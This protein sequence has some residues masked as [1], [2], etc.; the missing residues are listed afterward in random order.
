MD[1]HA[2][3]RR[4]LF[5]DAC[6][7][8]FVCLTE[9]PTARVGQ[10][11]TLLYF[12][13]LMACC[14]PRAQSK[15]LP[16]F[17]PKLFD[18]IST[19]THLCQAKQF[20]SESSWRWEGHQSGK[21]WG[22]FI[23]A[24]ETLTNIGRTRLVVSAVFT[25]FCDSSKQLWFLIPFGWSFFSSARRSLNGHTD[26]FLSHTD[27]KPLLL[28]VWDHFETTLGQLLNNFETW[29]WLLSDWWRSVPPPSG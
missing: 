14:Y 29:W 18:L 7:N 24:A 4:G 19:T 3:F 10:H 17:W 5:C 6:L 22:N 21:G 13:S 16:D 12:R 23:L 26:H 2:V 25:F 27:P 11:S 15:M 28:Q 1:L 9:A 8:T 20:I